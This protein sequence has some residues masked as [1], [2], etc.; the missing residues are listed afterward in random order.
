MNKLGRYRDGVNARKM[1][2][3]SMGTFLDMMCVIYCSAC[4][5]LRDSEVSE[6][7]QT[8]TDAIVDLNFFTSLEQKNPVD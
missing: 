3:R 4:A 2:Y 8:V 5:T 6:A 7:Q 1:D